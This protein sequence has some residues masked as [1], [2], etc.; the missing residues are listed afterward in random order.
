MTEKGKS[1]NQL[2]LDRQRAER[3]RQSTIQHRDAQRRPRLRRWARDPDTGGVL[4]SVLTRLGLRDAR[5]AT[6]QARAKRRRGLSR[7]GEAH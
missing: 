3:E 5:V 1:R 7:R 6:M 2:R 4:A